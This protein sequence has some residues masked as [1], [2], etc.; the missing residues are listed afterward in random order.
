MVSA[1]V[2]ALKDKK[3]SSLHAI[4]KYIAA[5]YKVNEK[6]SSGYTR[7]A[8]SKMVKSGALK[9]VKGCF[10]L[11]EK[12]KAAKKPA[13]KKA[14]KKPAAKKPAAKKPAAKKPAAKKAAAKKPAK[15]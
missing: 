5:T 13:A 11:A 1:A 2:A 7:T 15:K 6:S 4:K 8:V 12:P 14:A 10:K 9:Q 3:G